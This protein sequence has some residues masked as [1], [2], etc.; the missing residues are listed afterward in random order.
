MGLTERQIRRFARHILLPE[1]GGKGQ[2]RLLAAAVRIVGERALADLADAYLQAAGVGTAVEPGSLLR[3]EVHRPEL[4]TVQVRVVPREEGWRIEV[5]GEARQEPELR[6]PGPSET[7]LLAASLAAFEA[8]RII[9]NLGTPERRWQVD[10][11]DP[12]L[13]AQR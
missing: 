9:L 12:L 11:P 10:G 13:R 7:R 8:L 6:A 3:L 5:G 4:L 2:E 1:V